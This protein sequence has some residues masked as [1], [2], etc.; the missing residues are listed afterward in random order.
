MSDSTQARLS[1]VR[2]PRVQIQ[3][4][5]EDGGATVSRELPLVAGVVSDLSGDAS[6]PVDYAQ[7]QFVE[8]A[9]GGV[10]SLMRRV[11]PTL[12]FTVPDRISG[13]EDSEIPVNLSFKSI[14]DFDP[15]GVA[16]QLPQTASLLESR[17]RL[18]D[19]YGKLESNENLDGLLGEVLASADKKAQLR[20][21]LGLDPESPE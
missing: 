21:E 18:A 10:S 19:L 4:D 13:K 1:R 9:Q 11:G 2:P 16:A 20:A 5:V 12:E 14:D 3:Y 15:M 7:R 6:D 17:Q 8:V